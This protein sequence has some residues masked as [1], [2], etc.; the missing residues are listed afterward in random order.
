MLD[1][2]VKVT[3]NL[4]Q[5]YNIGV[6]VNFICLSLVLFFRLF[7]S[8]LRHL[9]LTKHFS[10]LFL[11]LS[12]VDFLS[13]YFKVRLFALL[14]GLSETTSRFFNS[15]WSGISAPFFDSFLKFK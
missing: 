8:L 10:E 11:G 2:H 6:T 12:M 5:I 15:S 3:V 9:H 7:L 14:F 4:A 13:L 1:P